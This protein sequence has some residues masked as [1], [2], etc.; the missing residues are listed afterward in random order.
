MVYEEAG[1]PYSP[2]NGAFESVAELRYIPGISS[3]VY[4]CILPELTVY[5]TNIE[6]NLLLSPDEV[7]ETYRWARANNWQAHLWSDPDEGADL[8]GT[9]DAD[10]NI[11]GQVIKVSV[12]LEEYNR[13]YS[14]YLRFTSSVE[15]HL[16]FQ[17]LT[18]FRPEELGAV[19]VSCSS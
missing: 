4:I 19:E 9:F 8:A 17:R 10:A 18:P 2:R 12:T 13:S 11:V 15:Q 16:N 5:S 6:P 1:V 7:K 14:T 3:N